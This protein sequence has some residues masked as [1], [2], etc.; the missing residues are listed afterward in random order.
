LA[1]FAVI[2]S[3]K[4]INEFQGQ[5]VELQISIGV[6]DLVNEDIVAIINRLNLYIRASRDWLTIAENSLV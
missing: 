1:K 3:S 6:G 4:Q 5:V 2:R